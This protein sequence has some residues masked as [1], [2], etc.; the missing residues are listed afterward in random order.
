[1]A[2]CEK[3]WLFTLHIITN[4]HQTSK[5]YTTVI[6]KHPISVQSSSNHLQISKKMIRIMCQ[7]ILT[8]RVITFPLYFRIVGI[9][10]VK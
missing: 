1:M 7:I 9:M 10:G 4:C 2:E 8:D 6:K 3:L 5:I